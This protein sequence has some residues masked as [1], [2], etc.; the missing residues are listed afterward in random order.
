MHD[1]DGSGGTIAHATNPGG[2]L[3]QTGN[4]GG[5]CHFDSA[6]DFRLDA[7]SP[8]VDQGGVSILW[9][10]VHEIGHNFGFDHHDSTESIMYASTNSL[11]VYATSYP[12]GIAGS[13]RDILCIKCVYEIGG[14]KI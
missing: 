5:D 12:N 10:A 9:T 14:Y 4:Y 11:N 6:N 2:T 3:G 8:S 13:P 1:I 7:T